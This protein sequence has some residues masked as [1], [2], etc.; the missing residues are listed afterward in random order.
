[1]LPFGPVVHRRDGL[2]TRAVATREGRMDIPVGL[3]G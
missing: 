1:M 3:L 2:A